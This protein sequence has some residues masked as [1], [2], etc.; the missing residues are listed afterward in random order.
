MS[1]IDIDNIE[2]ARNQFRRSKREISNAFLSAQ[3]NEHENSTPRLPYNRPQK[4]KTAETRIIC[5][6]QS[7]L[8]FRLKLHATS[9]GSRVKPAKL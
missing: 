6:P 1:I 4:P 2:I 9:Y 8:P 3:V 5:C 7:S